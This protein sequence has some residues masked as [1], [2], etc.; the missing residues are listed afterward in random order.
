MTAR[1]V[2]GV[3]AEG[4]ALPC[5]RVQGTRATAGV[6][7][8]AR[9]REH[10]PIEV[11][12]GA[13]GTGCP[14][15]TGVSS[16]GGGAAGYGDRVSL[17]PASQRWSLIAVFAAPVAVALAWAVAA[18]MP[19]DRV[20]GHSLQSVLLAAR[21][22]L[23]LAGAV[24]QLAMVA[25]GGRRWLHLP[26]AL[27]CL[28]ASGRP[29]WAGGGAAA[30]QGVG[31]L[32][33]VS[34]N[35]NAFSDGPDAAP[36]LAALQPDVLLVIERRAERVAGLDRV[37]DNYY[38]PMERISHGHAIHCRPGVACQAAITAEIG[39][40]SSHM[41][42]GLLR[43]A[44]PRQGGGSV[45][46]CIISLHA[47]PP[48][49]LNPTGLLP[50]ARRF[51]AQVQDGRAA[52]QWGPCLAGDPVLAMGDF[53]TV[54][55]TPAWRIFLGSGLRD[56]QAGRGIWRATWPAGGGWPDVPFFPLDQALIGP[57]L[58]LRDLH[59]ERIAGA[60]HLALAG[61]LSAR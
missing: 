11:G 23:W 14:R 39:S 45:D 13:P 9:V 60:D 25:L 10:G 49:P 27:A 57:G 59:R 55:G 30:A 38:V 20:W 5:R 61:V 21:S 12:P 16:H 15:L 18:P 22:W 51:A 24:L 17:R 32:R 4:G 40:D 53:N 46:A 43:V 37:A 56:V 3:A 41:P 7:A 31:G 6:V 54:P 34:A 26:V 50:Y 58:S 36:G 52:K 28:L 47:P 8:V 35:L 1:G 29:P 42:V 19:Q 33:I 2:G 48:A 44:V